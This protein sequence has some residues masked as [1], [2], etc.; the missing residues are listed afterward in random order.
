MSLSDVLGYMYSSQ[1]IGDPWDRTSVPIV[2]YQS[3]RN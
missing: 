3:D 1:D 2:H